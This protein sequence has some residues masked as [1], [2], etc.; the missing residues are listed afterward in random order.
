MPQINN[1]EQFPALLRKNTVNVEQVQPTISGIKRSETTTTTN[2]TQR[3]QEKDTQNENQGSTT[4][5]LKEV[6]DLLKGFNLNKIL[7]TIKQTV[8]KLKNAQADMEKIIIIL[9][10]ITELVN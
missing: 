3:N 2:N 8:V 10:A 9:E 7:T 5:S 6:L 1:K 4:S